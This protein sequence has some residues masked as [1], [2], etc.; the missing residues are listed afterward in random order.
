MATYSSPDGATIRGYSRLSGAAF[1]TSGTQLTDTQL[2]TALA[3]KVTDGEDEVFSRIGV[4]Y[5]TD[6]S[7]TDRQVRILKRAVS[8]RT[9]GIWLWEMLTDKTSGVYEPVLMGD[10]DDLRALLDLNDTKATELEALFAGA[11]TAVNT[12]PFALPAV[13][14]STYTRTSGDR[15]PSER[16]ALID[17]RDNIS[18]DDLDNG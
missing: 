2:E 6:S 4:G 7:L 16:I 18:S 5:E 1:S 12:K 17:Q 9:S 14:A 11:G 8:L 13:G 3:A 10:P 15:S